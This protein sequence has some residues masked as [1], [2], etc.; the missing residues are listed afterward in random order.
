MYQTSV[1]TIPLTTTTSVVFSNC[2]TRNYNVANPG[3]L[4][5]TPRTS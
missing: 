1:S 3:V 4:V 2:A 5:M